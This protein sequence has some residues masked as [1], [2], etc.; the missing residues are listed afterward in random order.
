MR[1]IKGILLFLLCFNITVLGHTEQI[2]TNYLLVIPTEGSRD[3]IHLISRDILSIDRVLGILSSDVGAYI[4]SADEISVDNISTSQ[5]K[6]VG[7]KSTMYI[8]TAGSSDRLHIRG[9]VSMDN[10]LTITSEATTTVGGIVG[11]ISILSNDGV[12]KAYIPIY[13]GS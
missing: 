12:T 5:I 13:S 2:T 4:I 6:L 11:R 8:F 3:V 9:R 10:Q 1:L 7:N